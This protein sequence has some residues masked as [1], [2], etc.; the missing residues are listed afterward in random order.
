MKYLVRALLVAGVLAVPAW[1]A[2]DGAKPDVP[3]GTFHVACAAR[4]T[5]VC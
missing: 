1:I 5:G 4:A 2:W 3:A